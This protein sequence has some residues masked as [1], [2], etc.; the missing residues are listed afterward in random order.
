MIIIRVKNF[1]TETFH[2]GKYIDAA[3]LNFT[4][5]GCRSKTARLIKKIPKKENIIELRLLS[6]STIKISIG[7]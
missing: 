4:L 2:S 6:K 7:I 1:I 3:I 5:R